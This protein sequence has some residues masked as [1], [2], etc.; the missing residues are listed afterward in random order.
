MSKIQTKW[1]TVC[2]KSPECVRLTKKTWAGKE[3]L[4]QRL[5]QDL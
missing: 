5:S 3:H 4:C 1:K 2:Y